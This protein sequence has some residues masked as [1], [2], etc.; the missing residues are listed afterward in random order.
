[1]CNFGNADE[2]WGSV[3]LNHRFRR[4]AIP[5]GETDYTAADFAYD[6][7]DGVYVLAFGGHVATVRDG[8]LLDSWNSENEMPIYYYWRD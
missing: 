6:H 8:A 7:P 4:Y 2:V 5:S 3:L 1:M